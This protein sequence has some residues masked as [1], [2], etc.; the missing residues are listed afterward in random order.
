MLEIESKQLSPKFE[1]L[2]PNIP[3]NIQN[4]ILSRVGSTDNTERVSRLF[5]KAVSFPSVSLLYWKGEV[6]T[7]LDVE[8]LPNID[9]DWKGVAA[10]LE[11]IIEDVKTTDSSISISGFYSDLYMKA[12]DGHVDVIRLIDYMYPKMLET[13]VKADEDKASVILSKITRYDFNQNIMKYIIKRLD[14]L[15]VRVSFTNIKRIIETGSMDLIEMVVRISGGIRDLDLTSVLST[16]DVSFIKYMIEKSH[17][18]EKEL[19]NYINSKTSPFHLITLLQYSMNDIIDRRDMDAY[20]TFIIS[21]IGYG[22]V[23]SDSNQIESLIQ[24][25]AVMACPSYFFHLLTFYNSDLKRHARNILRMLSLNVFFH[26]DLRHARDGNNNSDLI[27]HQWSDLLFT[28]AI[29][30]LKKEAMKLLDFG[31]PIMINLKKVINMLIGCVDKMELRTIIE[32][33]AIS[34]E[35]MIATILTEYL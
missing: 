19:K 28:Q 22:P 17:I 2:F 18:S 23:T 5:G 21:M 12:L 1:R 16:H 31:H 6:E 3:Q 10:W 25:S 24:Q 26:K 27:D 8:P 29:L 30:V 11:H 7:M 35:I 33:H 15:D 4:K 34:G 14:L 9:I 20:S 13:I 32:D